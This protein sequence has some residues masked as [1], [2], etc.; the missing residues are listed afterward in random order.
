MN[1]SVY[2]KTMENVR[3]YQD[4][5]LMA[6][7]NDRDEKMFM[8]KVHNSQFKYARLLGDTLVEAHMGKL[9]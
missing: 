2:G 6:M 7:N 5:K 9:V 3:K 8:K 1:N 4:V